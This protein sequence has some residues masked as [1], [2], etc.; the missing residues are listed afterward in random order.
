MYTEIDLATQRFL[1]CFF[2]IASILWLL[3]LFSLR[4]ISIPFKAA[5][6]ITIAYLLYENL[7]IN[8]VLT[9]STHDLLFLIF[10]EVAVGLTISLFVRVLFA[11]V[12]VSAEI[13]ALQTGFAF[14]RFMDP[15]TMAY[16]SVLE[17]FKNL[18]AI[19]I[20]FAIDAHHI[21]IRGIYVSFKE[22]P[23]GG[24]IFKPPLLEHIVAITARLFSVGLKLGAPVI[25]TLFFVE[26]ALGMLSR[27]IPQINIFIEGMPTKILIAFTILSLSLGIIS[28]GIAGLF[29]DMETGILR[30]IGLMV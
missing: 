30:I 15:S 18:L 6:S 25:I 7:D 3:P 2:R 11:T 12:Y 19:M 17:E 24:L 28:T 22:L 20:F 13:I 23:I 9:N 8:I 1:L 29:K 10:K 16:A 4:T 21:L 27:M 5:L 14:A 26:I